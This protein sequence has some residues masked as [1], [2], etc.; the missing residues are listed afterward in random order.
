MTH[1][2]AEPLSVSF[3]LSLINTLIYTLTYTHSLFHVHVIIIRIDE[4]TRNVHTYTH[5]NYD[6]LVSTSLEVRRLSDKC[7]AMLYWRRE[8]YSG[9]FQTVFII[10]MMVQRHKRLR[11]CASRRSRDD[12]KAGRGGIPVCAHLMHLLRASHVSYLPSSSSYIHKTELLS[13]LR[14]NRPTR[15]DELFRG[16]SVQR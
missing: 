3:S 2:S 5:F 11:R 1:T 13:K 7:D 4:T 8:R 12:L 9:R 14:E 10:R 6:S 16:K 15:S